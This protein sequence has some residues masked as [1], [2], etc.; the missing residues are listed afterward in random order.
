MPNDGPASGSE[1]TCTALNLGHLKPVRSCFVEMPP[2]ALAPSARIIWSCSFDSRATAS[3]L[4]HICRQTLQECRRVFG[5]LRKVIWS[6]MLFSRW[7]LLALV[8]CLQSCG[9]DSASENAAPHKSL[10][11][12][13]AL[14]SRPA[15][16]TEEITRELK[17]SSHASLDCSDCHSPD[18]QRDGGLHDGGTSI[19]KADCGHCHQKE[20]KAYEQSVHA[21]AVKLGQHGAANCTYCHGSHSILPANDP[22]SQVYRRNLPETCGGCHKN[23]ELAAKLGIRQP[24]AGL[25]YLDSLHG[26]ALIENGLLVAPTCTDCHSSTH[27]IRRAADPLSTVNRNNIPKTC[28]NCH[29]GPL[30]EFAIGIHGKKLAEGNPKAPVCSDCHTAHQIVRPADGFKLAS[31]T[32]CGKCHADRLHQYRESYHGRAS[33]LGNASVA[34][35][36]DCHGTH[37]I[38]PVS[39][40]ASSLSVNNRLDTCRKCHTNATSKFTSFRAHADFRDKKHYPILYWAFWIMTGLIAGTFAVWGLHTLLWVARTAT[41]YW[42]SPADFRRQKRQARDDSQGKL[43]TRFRPVDRFC[44][45]L[46]IISFLILVCT[47]MPLKFHEAHW[48]KV[49][50]ELL[51]GAHVAAKLHR[52]GAILSFL[53][54]AIHLTSLVGPVKRRWS[55]FRDDAGD[56]RIR[57]LLGF[58]FGPDSPLPNWDDVRDVTNHVRWFVGRGPKPSFD[59]FTYWEK[60]DYFAELWGSAFIGLSGLVMWFPVQV[61]R[62]LPG[63]VINLAQII[64]SQEALLAAGFILTFHFFN[65]HFRLEKFP[66]DT[67]MFSGRIT[68]AELKHERARQYERLIAEGRLHELE[69]R[70]DWGS[71]KYLF[72]IFGMSALIVGLLLAVGIFV[73]LGKLWFGH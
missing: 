5:T 27:T 16:K 33:D 64:H 59:R 4:A 37:T 67:V 18:G 58:V 57:R 65:S 52:F 9:S 48:A 25:L 28:G 71:W 44:H 40:P 56:F 12:P 17:L 61:S 62:W 72:T 70:D 63:W 55:S 73:G 19:G 24:K 14:R 43:Y 60:F 8:L 66:L 13:T 35:C 31:D 34:A 69:V 21:Q 30:D 38:L 2:I 36:F 6:N 46:I 20:L 39:D 15:A 41:V 47:G 1:A 45:F 26:K 54:L 53:Y 32:L 3:F 7:V 29:Q 49:A 42:R 22:R 10:A 51:G 23:A 11:A 50:F 68:E